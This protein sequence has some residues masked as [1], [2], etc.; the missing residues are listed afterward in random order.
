M[1]TKQC[2]LHHLTDYARDFRIMDSRDAVLQ[3]ASNGRGV[4][5]AASG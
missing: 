2:L 4:A 1:S 5:G 3:L